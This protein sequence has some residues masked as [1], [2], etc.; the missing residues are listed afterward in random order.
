[1]INQTRLGE[2]FTRL[3]RIN[4]PPLKENEI[5][6][7]LNERFRSLGAEVIVDDSATK[8]GG[9]TGNIIAKFPAFNKSSDP[10]VFSVH[11]DT[12][13]P[14]GDVVPVLIDG[15]FSS[16]GDTILGADDKAGIAELIEV[17]EVLREQKLPHGPVEVVITVAEEIGLVGAKHFDYSLLQSRRGYALDTDGLGWMVLKA[18]GANRIQVN[19]EGVA[20]HAGMAPERGLSA[21]QTAALAIS[22]MHLGRIDDETTANIGR[23][24]GG[25]ARNIVPQCVSVVGESRSHN[26]IKLEKQT[27]HMLDCFDQASNEMTC[28]I[29]GRKISPVIDKSVH[30]DFPSMSV[31]E[32]API[33]KLA[34]TAAENIGQEL[35][36]RLGGGGSDANIFNGHGIEMIILSTGMKKV[37][38]HDESV[39][40]ADMTE[41]SQLLLEIIQ[42]A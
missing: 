12:V 27:R 3:A 24:N 26:P 36:V 29:E 38:T 33:V 20:S 22:K 13:E 28:S 1:M 6:L 17:F 18:P 23:I 39:A 40:L 15:V 30:L 41:V 34:R 32:N 5:S 16:A 25:V 9:E 14:G 42:Q 21:I 11:M 31:G 19:I 10:L 37:H 35:K 2:E 7:Y 8:T 4:S